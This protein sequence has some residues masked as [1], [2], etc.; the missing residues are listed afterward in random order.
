MHNSLHPAYGYRIP[1][2][3][4]LLLRDLYQSRQLLYPSHAAWSYR[5]LSSCWRRHESQYHHRHH[6]RGLPRR[7]RRHTIDPCSRCRRLP[8]LAVLPIVA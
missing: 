5:N 3:T 4:W 8:V 7:R 2:A 6:G 1:A